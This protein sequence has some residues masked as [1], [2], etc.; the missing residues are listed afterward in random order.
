MGDRVRRGH[1]AIVRLSILLCALATM[2]SA[3]SNVSRIVYFRCTS[4]NHD[5]DEAFI[6]QEALRMGI[7]AGVASLFENHTIE[8]IVAP[9]NDS[10]TLIQSAVSLLQATGDSY[11]DGFVGTEWETFTAQLDGVTSAFR[12]PLITFQT[13]NGGLVPSLS[14]GWVA[15]TCN[16]QQIQAQIYSALLPMMS[17]SKAHSNPS[18]LP[19]LA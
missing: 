19:I 12:R 8:L 6:R 15:R 18:G 4:C 16:S 14:K 5:A 7:D 1:G 11:V 13:T 9:F 3:T 10:E 2:S 17:M